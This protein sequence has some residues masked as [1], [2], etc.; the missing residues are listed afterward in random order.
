MALPI[1][2]CRLDLT[3]VIFHLERAIENRRPA[4]H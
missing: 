2:N 3:K 4:I 1:A